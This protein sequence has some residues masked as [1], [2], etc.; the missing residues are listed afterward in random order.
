MRRRRQ[1][2]DDLQEIRRYLKLNDI[3]L[4]CTLWRTHFGIDYEPIIRQAM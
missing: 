2:L 4:H 1:L 3:A